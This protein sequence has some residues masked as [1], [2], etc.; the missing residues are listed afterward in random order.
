MYLTNK[1]S[2]RVQSTLERGDVKHLK[3]S[4]LSGISWKEWAN[5]VS[6]LEF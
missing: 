5:F 1:T 2:V 3:I 6:C 4:F